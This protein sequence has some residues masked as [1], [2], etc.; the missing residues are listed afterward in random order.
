MQVYQ[1]ETTYNGHVLS[2]RTRSWRAKLDMLAVL[3]S[4]WCLSPFYHRH[5]LPFENVR[6]IV[7]TSSFPW[8]NRTHAASAQRQE[9]CMAGSW[10]TSWGQGHEAGRAPRPGKGPGL[11]LTCRGPAAESLCKLISVLVWEDRTGQQASWGRGIGGGG[12][13]RA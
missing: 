11:E 9:P 7:V 13:C 1:G 4:R 12:P 10:A 8:G 5:G 2:T 6:S 3:G